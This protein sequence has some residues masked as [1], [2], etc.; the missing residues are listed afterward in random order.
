MWAG[1]TQ[2][3][4]CRSKFVWFLLPERYILQ[5]GQAACFPAV[6]WSPLKALSLSWDILL[7]PSTVTLMTSFQAWMGSAS[8]F[9]WHRDGTASCLKWLGGLLY[10]ICSRCLAHW[11][12]VHSRT[13]HIQRGTCAAEAGSLALLTDSELGEAHKEHRVS[14]RTVHERVRT[15]CSGFSGRTG[16]T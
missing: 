4:L 8:L 7:P 16:V 5:N 13:P 6:Q 10:T 14:V 15:N 9:P 11:T 2:T 12:P 3:S 1:E